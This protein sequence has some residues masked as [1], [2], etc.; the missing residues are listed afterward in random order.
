MLRVTLLF[1]ATLL[2]GWVFAW[3]WPAVPALL[4]GFWKPA[5]MAR[6]FFA[7][8][9]GSGA[10]WVLAAVWFDVRNDGLLSERL[11][12]VFHLPGG[13]GLIVATG[14]VGGLTAG[15]GSLFGA[16]FRRFW[17]SLHEALIEVAAPVPEEEG[18]AGTEPG[19][20]TRS[21]RGQ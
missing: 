19:L 3:W 7:A 10:A 5:R 15:L 4:T 11:A 12:P 18:E 8:L 16:R 6:G 9:I 13:T 1:V 2:G 21:A 17:S 14:V 20:G